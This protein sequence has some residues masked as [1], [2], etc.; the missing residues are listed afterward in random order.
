D[1]TDP[2]PLDGVIGE[3][4]LIWSESAI[5][6]IGRAK[7]FA[8]W[9]PLLKTEGWLV[10][11]DIVWNREPA[12]RSDKVSEFWAKEYPNITTA[13]DLVDELAAAGFSPL[14]PVL[15]A[16]KAWSNYYEPLRD[17]LRLLTKRGDCSQALINVMAEFEQEI[18]VYDCAGQDVALFF[19]L[20]RRD[21][22]S[23]AG[24]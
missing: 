9:R 24:R 10:F 5:Y 6:S 15:S 14:D 1:M 11:S 3:F 20:A 17:R 21:S 7:A 12:A 23:E 13:A 4:D 22:I 8:N 16:G 19:F 2:P 18:D